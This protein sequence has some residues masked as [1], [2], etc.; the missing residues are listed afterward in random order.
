[1]AEQHDAIALMDKFNDSCKEYGQGTG[2]TITSQW[3]V[4]KY[5]KSPVHKNPS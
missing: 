2:T 1:M 3:R 4:R 5:K